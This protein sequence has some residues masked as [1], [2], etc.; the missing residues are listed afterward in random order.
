MVSNLHFQSPNEV[1][2]HHPLASG[3]GLTP[4]LFPSGAM[5]LM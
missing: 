4:Q 3:T 5:L 2:Q 1:F